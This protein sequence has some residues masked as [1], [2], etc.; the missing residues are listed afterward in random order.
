MT[1]AT[2]SRAQYLLA[3]E[4]QVSALAEGVRTT[5]GQDAGDTT[6]STVLV[7]LGD[8]TAEAARQLGLLGVVRARDMVVAEGVFFD[9]EGQTVAIPYDGHLGVAGTLLMLVIRAKPD[10]QTGTTEIEG[11]VLL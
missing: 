7:D 2:L 11:E 9:L 10:L 4:R 1:A 5:W 8:A 3:P 6:Q